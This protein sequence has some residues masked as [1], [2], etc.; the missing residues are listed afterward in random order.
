M[1]ARRSAVGVAAGAVALLALPALALAFPRQAG[2]AWTTT[3]WVL[4]AVGF[5]ALAAAVPSLRAG[6]RLRPDVGGQAGD[7]INDLGPWTPAALTPVRLAWLVALAIVVVL[8]AAGVVTNDPYDGLARGVF[9]AAACMTGFIV[10]G[11]FLGLR[12]AR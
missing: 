9:D 8:G 1:L 6:V 5:A 12:T 11:R 7:L 3:A 10:L 4:T 2:T